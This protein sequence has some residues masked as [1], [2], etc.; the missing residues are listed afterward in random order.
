M[1][2]CRTTVISVALTVG[3][4]A[5]P[6]T[7]TILAQDL[8]QFLTWCR[9]DQTASVAIGDVNGDQRLDIVFG[10]GR[11]QAQPNLLFV[12]GNRTDLWFPARP[13]GNSATYAVVFTDMNRDGHL[14]L[15][16]GNDVGFHSVVWLNDGRGNFSA[17]HFFGRDDPTRD[18]AVGDLNGDG[19]PDIVTANR[20]ATN[21]IYINDGS[22]GFQDMRALPIE[23]DRSVGVG[24]GDFNGDGHLDIVV[25]NLAGHPHY[26]YLNDGVGRFSQATPFGT[27]AEDGV[28]GIKLAVGDL[29]RDGNTDVVFGYLG[30]EDRALFGDGKGSFPRFVTFGSGAHQT[31]AVAIGDINGDHMPDLVV[32]Y[33]AR[34]VFPVGPDGTPASWESRDPVMFIRRYRNEPNRV[35]LNDGKG[36]LRPGPAFGQPTPTR[37]IALGDVDGDGRLDIVV[38]H[39]C[40][41]NVIHLNR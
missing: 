13:L 14:D 24:S 41:E 26:L 19:F 29:D 6:G 15:V 18:V 34:E 39:D 28:D 10:N 1:S 8:S 11:H 21:K 27:L 4:L 5:N 3:T 25:A 37:S 2:A 9:G 17:E 35:Y 32:G 12:N 38:G 33:E 20:G 16:E 22:G 23:G 7:T 40:G 30:Q 36:N 31:R